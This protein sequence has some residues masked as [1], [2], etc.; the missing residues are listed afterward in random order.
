MSAGQLVQRIAW[1]ALALFLLAFIVL[2]VINH[3]V[4]ALIAALVFLILPRLVGARCYNVAHRA[5]I[6]LAVLVVYSFGVLGDWVPIFTAG[7]GWLA[8]IAV[9]RA[10]GDR[11]AVKT[12]AHLS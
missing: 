8:H 7:L 5:W 10:L 1:A 3:G 12:P 4:P 6:P 2:E 11:T 9:Q